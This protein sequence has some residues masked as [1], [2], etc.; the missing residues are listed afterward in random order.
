MADTGLVDA[1]LMEL[2]ANDAAL[3]A[4][5]PGGVYWGIRP[6]P[7]EGL[8]A[9]VIVMLFDHNEEPGLS[10]ITLYERTTYLVKAVIMAKSRTPT[11]Q[12][13]ARIHELLQ[14]VILDLTPAGYV[15]MDLH[16]V[17]R[18]A[19]PEL[20]PANKAVWHHGGGQYELMHYPN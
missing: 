11:R 17:D 15:A 2:L 16:R 8:T 20:D 9:F 5:C 13:A 18:V 4:L 3:G 6:P 12:A 14:G 7:D 10:G 1:A 19:Y